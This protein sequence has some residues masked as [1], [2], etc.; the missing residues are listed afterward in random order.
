VDAV[1]ARDGIAFFA[2]AFWA[3]LVPSRA[4]CKHGR[5][6]KH[7]TVA[8]GYLP[9]GGLM[10][11]G[12]PCD[13]GRDITIDY[14]V[15]EAAIGEYVRADHPKLSVEGATKQVLALVAAAVGGG[16]DE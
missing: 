9:G 13:G 15:M 1:R 3:A 8:E 10:T 5:Y 4:A 7:T 2:V 16:G 14:E 11:V 12:S 6:E